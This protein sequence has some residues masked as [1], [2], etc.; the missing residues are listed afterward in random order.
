MGAG[1]AT[2][3]KFLSLP[4]V[5]LIVAAI[6]VVLSITSCDLPQSGRDSTPSDSIVVNEPRA[7]GAVFSPRATGDA[8]TSIVE[9]GVSA[10][11]R[12][13]LTFTPDSQRVHVFDSATIAIY[14]NVK[15]PPSHRTVKFNAPMDRTIVI[16]LR[17]YKAG[18]ARFDV[19]RHYHTGGGAVIPPPDSVPGDTAPPP[20][21]PDTVVTPPPVVSIHPF[22]T[23]QVD[24]TLH[25]CKR[26]Y[27]I[28]SNLQ[29]ALDTAV[30][31]DCLRL[32]ANAVY[33]GNYR[34]RAKPGTDW[35]QIYSY[36]A[37]PDDGIRFQPTKYPN[38][39]TIRGIGVEP[40][41]RT[42]SSPDA[43][44]YRIMGVK[45]DVDTAV[46]MNYTIFAARNSASRLASQVPHHIILDRVWVQG[47]GQLNTQRCIEMN[48]H[49]S[50]VLNSW[51][52]GCHSTD[53]DAQ[54]IAVW[55]SP[56][57]Q[58]FSNNYLEG[59][60]EN[61][62]VGG[63]DP[64]I[65]NLVPTNIVTC[66]NHINKPIEWKTI[67]THPNGKLWNVKNSIETKN[68]TQWFICQN[69]VTHNWAKGQ[70]GFI[71]VM[72]S[73]NQSGRCYWCKAEKVA[74]EE[75]HF[76]DSPGFANFKA[77][78]DYSAGQVVNGDTLGGGIGM[79]QII[80]RNNYADKIAG[81][82]VGDR[83]IYQLLGHA[84][85]T[86]KTLRD[87]TI[88]VNVVNGSPNNYMMFDGGPVLR[89]IMRNNVGMRGAY[90]IFGSAKG[91]G[92]NAWNFFTR[93]AVAS[94]N[95][96]VNDKRNATTGAVEGM[97]TYPSGFVFPTTWPTTTVAGAVDTVALKQKL[98]GVVVPR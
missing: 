21:P 46:K 97:G 23:E 7:R 43:S 68:V 38:V 84:T 53:F 93:N 70:T 78:D 6:L 30:R 66:R 55:Y 82:V 95:V 8:L 15:V 32:P 92:L 73:S 89:L 77:L 49:H 57:V 37:F 29:M 24:I 17:S 69:V 72:K 3:G 50:A 48:A 65:P 34:L 9:E 33:R 64:A 31:G 12:W 80:V 60:G 28:G 1:M 40:A 98:A 13:S 56:G 63:A 87:I 22:I 88:E 2:K 19:T 85:D 96:I 71:L 81:N 35:I 79:N 42:D 61:I 45:F 47:H 27:I 26:Q 10:R 83:R 39:A 90:G 44:Y 94:G 5:L 25:P 36:A 41:M 52:E 91:E 58:N 54:A 18:L 59:S 20:P 11:L 16:R 51:V 62:M 4:L 67:A 14:A 74:I 75:N 86:T 76:Y